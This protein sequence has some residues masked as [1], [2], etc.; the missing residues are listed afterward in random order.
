MHR[1]AFLKWATALPLAVCLPQIQAAGLAQRVLVLVRLAG[2]NDGF[3]T[4]VP[5]ADPLYYQLRPQ[6]A[7]PRHQVLDIGQGMGLNPYLQALKPWWDAGQMAWVQ[8]VGYPNA[9]LSHFLSND[10][11]ETAYNVDSEAIQ[12]WV[13]QALK[14][15][16]ASLHGIAMGDRIGALAGKDCRALAMQSPQVFMSQVSLVED[17]APSHAN[18]ALA[19]ITTTQHRLYSAGQQI[20]R[21]L[22][23]PLN[24]GGNFASSKIGRDLES[25]ANMILSGVEARVYLVTL[26]G[27]DTHANQNNTQSNL[28]HH[29]AGALTSFAQAMQRAGC[30]N[31]VVVATYS[32]FG[33]RV[34]EN[35][36][37][38]TDHGTASV[39]LLLGGRVRGGIYGDAPRLDRLDAAGNVQHTVDFRSVYGTLTT[40]WLGQANPWAQFG[41]LP[42]LA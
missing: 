26:D 41:T 21:K 25:V 4:L 18:P 29:L 5:H 10:I 1:R 7:I 22:Q 16:S 13:G 33:R 32:E 37:K 14:A 36:A 19:H 38:G 24:L 28:L 35:H 2:G 23:H 15:N 8:G 27:F 6:V 20:T 30:W 9:S 3:N 34:Q 42:L 17:I 31:E 39:Q 40:H 12:G 11:W